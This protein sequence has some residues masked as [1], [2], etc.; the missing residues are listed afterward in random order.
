MF[1]KNV[2]V[3]MGFGKFNRGTT[4]FVTSGAVA[5]TN[6]PIGVGSGNAIT[7]YS[8]DRGFY[9]IYMDI[10]N[11]CTIVRLSNC[12]GI[13]DSGGVAINCGGLST[14]TS[15]NISIAAAN[16]RCLILSSASASIKFVL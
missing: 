13:G 11:N 3:G 4:A 10:E 14:A 1:G 16:E 12:M 8:T 15:N 9:N 5:R 2:V 6:I 7:G